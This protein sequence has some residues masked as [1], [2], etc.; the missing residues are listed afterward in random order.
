MNYKGIIV[1]ETDHV[2]ILFCY[3]CTIRDLFRGIHYGVERKQINS[4]VHSNT[5]ERET[6][7]NVSKTNNMDTPK[8]TFRFRK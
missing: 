6:Q 4:L 7:F 3:A 8:M 2:S 5:E 1:I